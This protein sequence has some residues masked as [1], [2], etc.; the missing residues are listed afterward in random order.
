[1]GTKDHQAIMGI[2]VYMEITHINIMQINI[3]MKI[4]NMT[5]KFSVCVL[6]LSLLGC[7]LS[8]G[9][10]MKTSYSG[11]ENLSVYIESIDKEIKITEIGGKNVKLQNN[12]YKI[13]N[14]DQ[15]AITVWGLPEFF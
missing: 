7:N 2:M 15:I 6:A 1:M 3:F 5:K 4:M 12:D 10:H 13:G 9:M 8:P 11:S 14:G